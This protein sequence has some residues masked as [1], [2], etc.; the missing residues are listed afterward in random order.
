M[1]Y[2]K[3]LEANRHLKEEEYLN[4][5]H[6][7]P[8]VCVFKYLRIN[9]GLSLGALG[10]QTHLSKNA[11]VRA[12]NGTYANP[13]PALLDFW[14]RKQNALNE[15]EIAT[16]YE[17]FQHEQRRRHFHYFGPYLQ[18]SYDVGFPNHPFRQL[19]RNRPSFADPETALPVGVE[20]VSRALCLPVD[21]LRHWEKK[22]RTQLSVPKAVLGVLN[23]IGYTQAE[24]QEYAADY[25]QWRREHLK[26]T[27]T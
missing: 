19:R 22:Y 7:D 1:Q 10:I 14:V 27:Y 17:D 23:Q 3:A 8:P 24:V 6:G 16:A 5:I 2:S 4:G 15:P 25:T 20:E 18:D 9:A 26:V 13:L 21:T 12:E 11:L